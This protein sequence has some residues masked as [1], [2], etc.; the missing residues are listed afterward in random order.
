VKVPLVLP[1]AIV[2]EAG[3]ANA[4]A[5][6]FSATTV[7]PEPAA[8]LSP[9]VHAADAEV[10][11]VAGLQAKEVIV[12]A[13]GPG[14]TADVTILPP[15]D[16][17]GRESPAAE[18]P[19]PLVTPMVTLAAGAEVK[20]TLTTATTPLAIAMAFM[21]EATQVYAAAP[22]EQLMDLFAA[23]DA[24]AVTVNLATLDAG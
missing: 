15:A 16:E 9:T 20:V 21:P 4:A 14:G 17:I 12:T 5:L 3:T 23:V 18:T 7:P 24:L 2:T 6:E 13:P 19:R 1:L 11:R 10:P 8:A 22:P